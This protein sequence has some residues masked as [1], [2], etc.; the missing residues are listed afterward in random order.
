MAVV[1]LRSFSAAARSLDTVQSNVSAHVSR[2]E[3]ELGVTLIDRATTEPTDEGR[4]VLSRARRI[5][6]ENCR[7]A[8]WRATGAA[9]HRP[10]RSRGTAA[11]NPGERACAPHSEAADQG[12]CRRGVA[13][14]VHY[15]RRV[16]TLIRGCR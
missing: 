13:S 9:D 12:Q 15:H 14:R 10:R 1:E 4:A 11:R 8:D 16:L 7:P 6:A 2:L 5:E 3:N